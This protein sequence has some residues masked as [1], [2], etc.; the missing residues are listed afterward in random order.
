MEMNS[1]PFPDGHRLRQ[2]PQLTG[3]GVSPPENL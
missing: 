2:N 3:S 1:F